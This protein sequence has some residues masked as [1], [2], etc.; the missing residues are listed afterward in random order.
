MLRLVGWSVSVVVCCV[1]LCV[2]VVVERRVCCTLKTSVCPSK[3][4]PCVCSKRLR[5]YRHH[6]H[7]LKHMCAWCRY[8]RGRFE[9]THTETLWMDTRRAGVGHRQFCSPKFAHGE[10]SRAPEVHQRNPW[11]SPILSLRTG[12]TRHVPDFSNHS[13]CLMKLSS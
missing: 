6:A 5:V 7:M 13:L 8:T 11:I 9:R 1:S 3:T 2:V 4:P 10:L 12:R